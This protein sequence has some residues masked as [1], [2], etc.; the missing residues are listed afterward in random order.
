MNKFVGFKINNLSWKYKWFT[1]SDFKDK[2]I[3][4]LELV[5]R[6]QYFILHNVLPSTINPI[7]MSKD[8]KSSTYLGESLQ[9][10]LILINVKFLQE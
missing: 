7:A 3:W 4:K 5:V 10:T 1:P 2:G 6:T 9:P 8:P